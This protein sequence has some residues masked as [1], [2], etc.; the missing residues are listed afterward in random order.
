VIELSSDLL[1]ERELREQAEF[2][3]NELMESLVQK[4][5]ELERIMKLAQDYK[6][7]KDKIGQIEANLTTELT[8]WKT[9][10]E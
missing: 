9:T 4:S 7:W 10:C 5:E 2:E 6:Q 3:K 8:H 1:T